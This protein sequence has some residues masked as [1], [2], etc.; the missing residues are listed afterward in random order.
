MP[1]VRGMAAAAALLLAPVFAASIT[2]PAS[3][4]APSAAE[5]PPASDAV[6]AVAAWAIRSKDSG[7]LPF[8]IVD[9]RAAR[10]FVFGAD[11]KLKG[12]GPAL[13]GIAPG[14]RSQ[15]YA[16]DRELS[17]IPFPERTTPAGR[18]LARWG[19]A[20]DGKRT[21]WVDFSTAVSIHPLASVLEGEHR[22]ARLASPTPMDNRITFGCINVTPDFFKTVVQPT[23]KKTGV[24]YVLPETLSLAQAFPGFQPPP[25]LLAA[26]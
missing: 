9:K 22:E 8:A 24:F 16:G 10:V 13:L 17:S 19:P 6:V 2:G 1:R 7:G 25:G 3:A 15:P 5:N 21:L 18:F 14:D 23:F 11:G 12:E 4:Q 26:R 20:T